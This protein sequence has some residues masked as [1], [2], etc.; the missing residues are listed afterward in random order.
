MGVLA[1]KIIGGTAV[2]RN[3]ECGNFDLMQANN[4]ANGWT[5][6]SRDCDAWPKRRWTLYPYA[7]GNNGQGQAGPPGGALTVKFRKYFQ[8]LTDTTR[9]TLDMSDINGGLLPSA[10]CTH[11]WVIQNGKPLP[12]EGYTIDFDT[13]L[14]TILEDW[15]APG[16]SYEVRFDAF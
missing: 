12:C 10:P 6:I 4:P 8:T 14:I 16:A 15:R 13:A 5:V 1:S 2:L 9:E 3:W 11:L 7:S